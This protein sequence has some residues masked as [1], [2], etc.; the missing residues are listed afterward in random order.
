MFLSSEIDLY[1]LEKDEA[2]NNFHQQAFSF[3]H[4]ILPQE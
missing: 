4:I 2:K 3:Q 1:A